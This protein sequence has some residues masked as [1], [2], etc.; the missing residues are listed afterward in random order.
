VLANPVSLDYRGQIAEGFEDHASMAPLGV[1]KTEEL[2][3]IARRTAALELTVATRAI[4]LRGGPPLGAGTRIA[5]D[6]AREFATTDPEERW[7][8]VD[9]LTQA[10]DSGRLVGRRDR[11]T[12]TRLHHRRRR[13]A[14]RRVTAGRQVPD[15]EAP[16]LS[17]R[18]C[19]KSCRDLYT[20]QSTTSASR[21]QQT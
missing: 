12:R 2:L 3:S 4:D 16:T 11:T 18:L 9:G 6:I 20:A 8:D 10:I 21:S 15:S 1:R 13:G 7:P 14:R 5:R 19:G 17:S